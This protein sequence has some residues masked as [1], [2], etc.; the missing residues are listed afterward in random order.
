[1]QI[2]QLIYGA[3]EKNIREANTLE[4]LKGLH[5]F[6]LLEKKEYKQ[7]RGA[8]VF[9]RNIENRVQISFGLQTHHI[10]EGRFLQAVLALKMNIEGKSIEE[11]SDKLNDEFTRHTQF[12]S[13]I[14]SEL[15]KNR[16]AFLLF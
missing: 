5:E 12:V 16:R 8:Y 10:P 2:Y 9:L 4:A 7:L 13:Y 1:M 15:F 6:N 11:L 14:F 3:K